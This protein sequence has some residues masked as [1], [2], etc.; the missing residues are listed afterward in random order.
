MNLVDIRDAALQRVAG[1]RGTDI[2]VIVFGVAHLS[3][4]ILGVHD[5][6]MGIDRG[7]KGVQGNIKADVSADVL[8]ARVRNADV[9]LAGY[10][11]PASLQ[12]L[13]SHR[14]P[15]DWRHHSSRL[16]RL[17]LSG[18]RTVGVRFIGSTGG[19]IGE[20]GS[21]EESNQQTLPGRSL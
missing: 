14:R 13:V 3:V 16:D 1:V 17:L 10:K 5:A 15:F 11:M 4:Q 20:D 19:G 6:L 21:K 12:R 7:E 9:F 2:V 18:E 8:R